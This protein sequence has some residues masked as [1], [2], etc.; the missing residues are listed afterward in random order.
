MAWTKVGESTFTVAGGASTET[1]T[2]PG[3]P[4]T[5]DIVIIALASDGDLSADGPST[6]DY[7]VIDAP[8]SAVPGVWFGY[9]IMGGTPDTQVV[10]QQRAT[11]IQAGILQ[12]W[13]GVDTTTPIDATRTT[14]AGASGMPNPPSYNPVTNGVLILAVGMLDDDDTAGT[15]T[16]PANYTNLVAA[17][18]GQASTA[19]GATA[20][21][22]SRELVTV[23]GAEDPAA[24]GGS[25][26]DA[27]TSYTVG[28]RPAAAAATSLIYGVPSPNIMALLVT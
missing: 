16:A 21:I 8:V 12:V 9:K 13:R 18:T 17:D 26:S 11:N 10:V 3:T 28:L 24:F 5:D 20:M 27:W 6:A 4:A 7:V 14:T 23:S 15:V 2:L 19:A 22:A 25:G 1:K